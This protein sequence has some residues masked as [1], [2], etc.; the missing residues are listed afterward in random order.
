MNPSRVE[1]AVLNNVCWYQAMFKAHGLAS[2]VDGRVWLS[3]AAAPA[4]HSN[5]VVRSPGTSQHEVEACVRTLEAVPLRAGWSMKDSYASLDLAPLGF[6]QLF[7]AEWIWRDAVEAAT[8]EAA[9]SLAWGQVSTAAALR[10]WEAAWSGDAGNESKPQG[11]SQFPQ[12]L[13]ASPDHAFFA[14]RLEGRLVAGGIANR[15]PG[16]AGLSNVF[17][18]AAFA[19]EAWH[20]LVVCIANTFPGL[21]IVGYERGADLELAQGAGFVPTGPLRVWCRRG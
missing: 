13:L 1:L 10:E 7:Q 17:C 5:L 6:D 3:H 19:G 4:F 12:G 16:A 14:G 21:P 9:A 11:A 15:S 20:A 8:H 2:T 18:P